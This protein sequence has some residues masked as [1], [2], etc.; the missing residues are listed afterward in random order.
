M[1]SFYFVP[2]LNSERSTFHT[3]TSG[4]IKTV[5]FFFFFFF[6]KLIYHCIVHY[7]LHHLAILTCE[8]HHV[9]TPAFEPHHVAPLACEFLHVVDAAIQHS[10]T[11][12]NIYAGVR[13][14]LTEVSSTAVH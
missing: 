5:D 14:Q 3:P 13:Q 4:E 8:L 9:I 6:G 11:V 1:G 2:L 7:A 12:S 10:T